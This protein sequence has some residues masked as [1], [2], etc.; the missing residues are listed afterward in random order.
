MMIRYLLLPALLLMLSA[1][2]PPPDLTPLDAIGGAIVAKEVSELPLDPDN[3]IWREAAVREISLYPQRSVQPASQ[4]TAIETVRVQALH[5]EKE[6][7]LRLEWADET[8]AQ[9]R[10][11]G[12]FAD[13]VAVQWPLNYGTG[14][15]LPYVGMGHK[16][17]PVALWFWR[18]DGD[19]QTLA[20][21]GFGTLTKQSSD[22][23]EVKGHWKDGS[24][25]VVFKRAIK[26]EGEHHISL[27]PDNQGLVPLALAVWNGEKGQR[28]GRKQLSAWR[29][30]YLEDGKVD[31][32]YLQQL[33][34]MA[35]AQGNVETGKSLMTEKG[36][37]GCHAFP[38]NPA[39]PSIG[40]DL[41]YAGGIHHA[42]YLL[43]SL[44]EPSKVV[45][46]GKGFYTVHN[47]EYVSLMPPFQGTGQEQADI[48]AYLK[49]LQ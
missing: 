10:D 34:S 25:R 17:A 31:S 33:A 13:A 30:L 9:E 15:G 26:S 11:I 39:Q 40:P 6:L 37:I 4:Q 20:A 43:E 2:A 45:S 18:S 5:N 35:P 46:P 19:T 44:T 24:W 36:C 23:V 16:G 47:G 29:V 32:A 14:M 21:E 38:D 3:A 28:N 27:N 49:T 7:A 1:C 22:G 41:G 8:P 42:D 12:Q 48:I